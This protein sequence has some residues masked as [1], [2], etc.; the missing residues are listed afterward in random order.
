MVA[1]MDKSDLAMDARPCP[2]NDAWRALA[3]CHGRH[4][5]P[6]ALVW[7]ALW[8]TTLGGLALVVAGREP[9]PLWLLQHL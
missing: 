1:V 6:C 8:T 2:I 5:I 3:R 9:W 7:A 4:L